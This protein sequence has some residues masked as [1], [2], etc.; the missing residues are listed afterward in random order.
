M[1]FATQADIVDVGLNHMTIELTAW[2]KRVE[3]LIEIARPVTSS[4]GSL[5]FLAEI[6]SSHISYF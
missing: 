5:A 6:A 1:A 4:S 3:A 2:P